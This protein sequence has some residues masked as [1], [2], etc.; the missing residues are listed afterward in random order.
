M[1]EYFKKLGSK[2]IIYLMILPNIVSFLS[3]Y[4]PPYLH[5]YLNLPIELGI[6]FGI[7]VFFYA[8]Y[9][10][11][12]DENKDKLN[13]L[14][15]QDN[16]NLI[17]EN[18]QNI[19]NSL[20]KAF[21]CDINNDSELEIQMNSFISKLRILYINNYLDDNLKK[22]VD[23]EIQSLLKRIKNSKFEKSLPYNI[24]T[25]NVSSE[26]DYICEK[27]YNQYL[28]QIQSIIK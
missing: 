19:K 10:V 8:T 12:K 1:F 5:K 21:I 17:L 22:I 9:S 3:S 27:K 6:L 14:N 24:S 4:L 13:I 28:K 25:G 20:D 11:W 7:I 18:I 23:L 2:W 26:I 15:A 16:V